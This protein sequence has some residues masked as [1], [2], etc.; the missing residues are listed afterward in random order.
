MKS[1]TDLEKYSEKKGLNA[2]ELK[3][4]AIITMT[5]DHFTDIFYPWKK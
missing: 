5:I 2:N 4:I 3:I 1:D